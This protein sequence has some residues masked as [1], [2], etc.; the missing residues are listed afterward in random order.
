MK[1]ESFLVPVACLRFVEFSCPLWRLHCN[2]T[3]TACGASL[4][5]SGQASQSNSTNQQLCTTLL[6]AGEARMGV[7]LRRP[8][9]VYEVSRR[10]CPCEASSS[11][12]SCDWSFAWAPQVCCWFDICL[13]QQRYA[14]YWI[15]YKPHSFQK[16]DTLMIVNESF[17]SQSVCFAVGQQRNSLV[18]NTPHQFVVET[19]KSIDIGLH[20]LRDKSW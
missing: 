11:R 20:L 9:E 8:L 15:L 1:D 2:G 13:P 7:V 17:N 6:E 18:Q 16:E 12:R 19:T 14:A 3:A 5:G 10:I 4:K